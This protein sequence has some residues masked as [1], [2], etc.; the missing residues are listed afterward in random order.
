MIFLILFYKIINRSRQ[1]SESLKIM[2]PGSPFIFSGQSSNLEK[3]SRDLEL[4]EVPDDV[5][6]NVSKK[7]FFICINT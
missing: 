3:A 4:L 6:I 2:P 5:S 7:I 1:I